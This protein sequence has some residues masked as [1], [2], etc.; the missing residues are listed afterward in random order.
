MK[1]LRAICILAVGV[2][3]LSTSYSEVALAAPVGKVTRVQKQAQVGSSPARVGTPVS[4]GA[5]LLTG[6][7]SRLEVTFVDGSKLSL[8]ENASL[9]VDRFVYSPAK[10]VGAMAMSKSKGAMRFTT[11]N[12]GKM[13]K[14][15]VTLS[16]PQGAL[17]VRGTDFW[18][19]PIWGH[20]GAY[21]VN[22]QVDV[23]RRGRNVRLRPGYG[24]DF[25]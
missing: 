1:T 10:G 24:M 3:L 17:A 19:G 25:R 22:G 21:V 2:C 14:K 16:T 13:S 18:H 5:R 20:H 6:P 23:K 15:D 12:I 8:G 9:V 4:M 7:G 11:G